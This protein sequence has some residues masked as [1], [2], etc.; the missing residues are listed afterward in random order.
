MRVRG[1][2]VRRA[3]GMANGAAAAARRPWSKGEVALEVCVR[4]YEV[5]GWVCASSLALSPEGSCA[6]GSG[7]VVEACQWAAVE[8]GKCRHARAERWRPRPAHRISV[9]DG[10]LNGLPRRGT[11]HRTARSVRIPRQKA[12][13]ISA[14]HT[15]GCERRRTLRGL[16]HCTGLVRAVRGSRTLRTRADLR[17][18]NR[19]GQSLRTR[20]HPAVARH[21]TLHVYILTYFQIFRY[22]RDKRVNREPGGYR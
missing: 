18:Q 1:E 2:G 17:A 13:R 16:R 12:V 21:T 19:R 6:L 22:I 7:R 8:K 20:R 5:G 9:D 4:V 10:G 11:H 14:S 15:P 3:V